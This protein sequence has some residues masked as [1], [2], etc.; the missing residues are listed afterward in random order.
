MLSVML[1]ACYSPKA[2]TDIYASLDFEAVRS[3]MLGSYMNATELFCWKF[4][5]NRT[6]PKLWYLPQIN[7]YIAGIL[8]T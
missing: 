6:L 5:T 4:N 1:L 8:R 3:Y 2:D 7:F